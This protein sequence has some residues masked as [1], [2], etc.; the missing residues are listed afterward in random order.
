ML[1]NSGRGLT[2]YFNVPVSDVEVLL[3]S[4][5]STL[6]SVGGFC[7]GTREVIDHQ[8]LSGA[9]YCFSASAPP[10]TCSMAQKSLEIMQVPAL[11]QRV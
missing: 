1:G 7:V 4:N 10:F 2:E 6:A 3:G 8:R 5:E 9:G 11:A